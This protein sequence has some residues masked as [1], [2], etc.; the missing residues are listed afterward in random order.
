MTVGA[1]GTLVGGT[2][3]GGAALED[4]LPDG[5]PQAL[6]AMASAAVVASPAT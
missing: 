6:T 1:A 3:V 5:A 2:L 4:W